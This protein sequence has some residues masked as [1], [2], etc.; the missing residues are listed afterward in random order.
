L[1]PDRLAEAAVAMQSLLSERDWL[2]DD[3]FRVADVMCASVRQGSDARAAGTV[4]GTRGVR[5]VRRGTPGI[6]AGGCDLG[7]P[8]RLTTAGST[9]A[10]LPACIAN[11]PP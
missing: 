6:R 10:T 5:A 4:A 2:V 1:A 9:G 8:P 3:R 11:E 7:P